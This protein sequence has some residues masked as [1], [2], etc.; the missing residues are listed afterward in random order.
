LGFLLNAV[1]KI[2]SAVSLGLKWALQNSMWMMGTHG[3]L[4]TAEA[5]RAYMLQDLAQ[6]IKRDVLI[7][8][9]ED[10]HFVPVEQVRQF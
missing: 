6:R 8:A 2:K 9:G 5:F 1:V 3:L 10:D 7:L 4:E